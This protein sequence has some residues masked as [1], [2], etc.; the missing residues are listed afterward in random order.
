[1]SQT[2]CHLQDSLPCLATDFLVLQTSGDWSDPWEEQDAG[3]QEWREIPRG[4]DRFGLHDNLEKTSDWELFAYCQAPGKFIGQ[5]LFRQSL[6]WRKEK[7]TMINFKRKQKILSGHNGGLIP[8]I[9]PAMCR[10]KRLPAGCMFIS[11]ST[12][13]QI[14]YS[15]N[16][17]CDSP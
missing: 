10:K 13:S 14:L 15:Y 12:T 3:D 5:I 6:H 9:I 1:M 8:G 16:F 4:G 11:V 2:E 17:V 7:A